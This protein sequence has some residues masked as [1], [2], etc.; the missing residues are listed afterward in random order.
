METDKLASLDKWKIQ[1]YEYLHDQL[2]IWRKEA[3]EIGIYYGWSDSEALQFIDEYERPMWLTSTGPKPS[4][5][6]TLFT[7]FE[8]WT[9]NYTENEFWASAITTYGN[10]KAQ[11]TWWRQALKQQ[12]NLAS[13]QQPEPDWCGIVEGAVPPAWNKP[14]FS[15]NPEKAMEKG[16]VNIPNSRTKREEL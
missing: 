7:S 5:L 10:E 8:D 1:A 3:L 9:D 2:Q 4:Q 12:G 14:K 16:Y 13:T 15:D 11:W 6:D